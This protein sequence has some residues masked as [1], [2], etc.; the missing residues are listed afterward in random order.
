MDE[1]RENARKLLKTTR[2]NNGPD[3]YTQ[4]VPTYNVEFEELWSDISGRKDDGDV[5]ENLLV[6]EACL[7]DRKAE[8]PEDD[9]NISAANSIL[10][11]TLGVLP[12]GEELASSWSD[13]QLADGEQKTSIISK[14]RED[15]LKATV[16][17][18]VLL[19][20]LPIVLADGTK[21]AE[22]ILPSLAM[23]NSS[24]DPWTTDE[25][26]R[27]TTKLLQ[28]YELKLR[29]E[30]LFGTIIEDILRKKV[31][32]AFSKT[33]TPAITPAG[34]KDIHP[35]PQPSFDPT[36]FDTGTKPWKFKEGYIVSILSWIVTRYQNTEYSM[37]ERH[38]PLLVPAILS[39][40]DDENIAY[41]A[42]GCSL[43]KAVLGPLER[44]KSDILRRTNLD[45][46]FQ[47]ALS[48][49]LLSIPTITPE[50]ESVYLLSLA[51][52][53]IFSVIRTRFAFFANYKGGFSKPQPTK[54]KAEFE[55]DTQLRIE[56]LSRIVRH[57]IISSYLHTSSPRP[58][59]DTSISSYPHPL[60]STLL[61][62]QLAE[63]VSSLEIEATKYLQDVVPLLSS[64][65][66]NPFGLAYIPLLIA[67]GQCYQSVIL[68]CWPRLSRWRG[69]ILAGICTC[70]LRLCDDKEDGI[71][72]NKEESDD[73]VQL[74]SVLQGLVV[75]LKAIELE[76]AADFEIE[77][78]TMVDADARLESLLLI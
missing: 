54:P 23:F 1:C 3:I 52:P 12:P 16:G 41:K 39:F 56:S 9:K 49:C 19:H 64:T 20:I 45:S 58:T 65:L 25:A 72:S 71:F 61:L 62:K 59:E 2:R 51:Y 5:L 29:E 21:H 13:F 26:A 27:M 53:A 68:N 50:K 24:S 37:I 63:A 32:P 11:W 34:R 22:D 38:F 36:L 70:W 76:K 67:A 74:R 30:D 35:I 31:K 57:H 18:R 6:A 66:T 7:R 69:D 60:L 44:A 75:L 4:D 73:R 33:K 10:H 78:K 77:L 28:E 55:R 15:R 17:L 48:H 40:I 43:L 14:Y 8:K 47:D 42:A 46:V